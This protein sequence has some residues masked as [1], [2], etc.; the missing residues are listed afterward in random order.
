MDFSRICEF[1]GNTPLFEISGL[2]GCGSIFVKAEYMNPSGSV[3]DRAALYILRGALLRGEIR[4]GDEIIEA[5]SGNMGISLAMI[6]AAMGLKTRIVMPESA[7]RERAELIRA[8]GGDVIFTPAALGMPGAVKEAERL[9]RK[10]GTFYTRQFDNRDGVLA[11]YETTGPEILASLLEVPEIIIAGVGTGGTVTGVSRYLKER[12]ACEVIAVEPRE[13]AVLSGGD[14]SPH[15]IQ[16]LG[17]GFVPRILD[18]RLIDRV[19][20]VGTSEAM[21][22][23]EILL[24]RYGLGVGIS[25]GAVIA[26]AIAVSGEEAARGKRIVALLPDSIQRYLSLYSI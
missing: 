19:I 20:T 16:G 14:P 22:Y 7:T 4:S 23:H 11:H 15:G 12:G 8:Y 2:S 10:T 25:S 3:K 13:S 26:A 1:V 17:A 21:Y 5:T 24:K 18:R 6:G 9:S